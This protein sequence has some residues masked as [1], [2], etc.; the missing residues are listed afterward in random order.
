MV[1]LIDLRK[2]LCAKDAL[3]V[4]NLL[5]LTNLKFP[6]FLVPAYFIFKANLQPN[7]VAI[8]VFKT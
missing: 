7:Q 6:R 5:K 8:P 1:F 4:A 3:Y 2:R